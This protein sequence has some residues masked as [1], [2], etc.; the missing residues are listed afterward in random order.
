MKNNILLLILALFSIPSFGVTQ[1]SIYKTYIETIGLDSS[2]NPLPGSD[3]STGLS[4]ALSSGCDDFNLPTGLYYSSRPEMRDSVLYK[5][6]PPIQ[7]T[8][9]VPST[10]VDCRSAVSALDPYDRANWSNLGL[11]KDTSFNLINKTCGPGINCND[12]DVIS[13]FKTRRVDSIDPT[14]GQDAIRA[15]FI[16]LFTYNITSINNVVNEGVPGNGGLQDISQGS[17]VFKFCGQ[18]R[19]ASTEGTA[20]IF[21]IRPEYKVDT[22]DWNAFDLGSSKRSGYL[23]GERPGKTNVIRGVDDTTRYLIELESVW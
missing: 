16:D 12:V 2:D 10:Q 18:V 3:W 23:L 8:D 13:S 22:I 7:V 19:D 6:T 5:T 17:N 11:V 15:N 20:S 1:S 9:Y 21:A 14:E 4:T